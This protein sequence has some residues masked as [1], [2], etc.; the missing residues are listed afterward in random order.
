MAQF[1]VHRNKGPRRDGIPYLIV[2]QSRRFDDS[3]RRVVIPLLDGAALRSTD[4]TFTPTFSVEGKSVVLN[5][6]QIASVSVAT[7]G[8][9][10]ASLA[11]EGDRIIAAIDQLI[12]R[13]W[14]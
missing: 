10:V 5:P 6:L 8:E 2:V 4:Q 7:L 9:H 11:S 3:G 1:D 13:A 12:T 14:G